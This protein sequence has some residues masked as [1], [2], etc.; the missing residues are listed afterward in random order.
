VIGPRRSRTSGIDQA[1]LSDFDQFQPRYAATYAF[2]S[3]NLL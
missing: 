3:Y 1:W 2:P